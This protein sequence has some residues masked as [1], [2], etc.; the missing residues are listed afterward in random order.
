MGVTLLALMKKKAKRDEKYNVYRLE[1]NRFVYKIKN[2][3]NMIEYFAIGILTEEG[4]TIF[5][6]K[7]AVNSVKSGKF[8][9][10]NFIFPEKHLWQ[11]EIEFFV[12]G[13]DKNNEQIGQYFTFYLQRPILDYERLSEELKNFVDE[14]KGDLNFFIKRHVIEESN[15]LDN[16]INKKLNKN[17]K[18]ILSYLSE[19]DFELSGNEYFILLNATLNRLKGI[20][21]DENTEALK[22]RRIFL[23]E[24]AVGLFRELY[25][26]YI[27]WLK[28]RNLNYQ[29]FIL[30]LNKEKIDK[31]NIVNYIYNDY[32]FVLN[33]DDYINVIMNAF[34]MILNHYRP[35]ST[36]TY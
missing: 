29:N 24:L 13:L 4:K 27:D 30:F 25:N 18:N 3:K 12:V 15:I 34:N 32:N 26:I 17:R 11:G 28:K 1:E 33:E 35:E 5:L 14:R 21:W 16:F 6:K 19:M 31:E 20:K 36:F 10:E 9:D 23:N 2:Q 7:Y 8:I 22:D